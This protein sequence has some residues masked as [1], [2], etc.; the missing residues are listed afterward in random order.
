MSLIPQRKKTPE[1]LAAL[2]AQEFPHG[3]PPPLPPSTVP[4]YAP[5]SEEPFTSA[6]QEAP[7]PQYELSSQRQRH[8]PPEKHGVYHGFEGLK[9][10]AAHLASTGQEGLHA[11]IPAAHAPANKA[12]RKI[13]PEKSGTLHVFEGLRPDS[14]RE[15]QK[16]QVAPQAPLPQRKHDEREIMEMRRRDAFQTRPP[17]QA[18]KNMALHP[19]LAGIFYII[20]AAVV[21]LTVHYWN[22]L[23]PKNFY[24][25]IAGCSLLSLLSLWLYFKKARARHHAA[26]LFGIALVIAGFV[27][28]LTL[29][30]PYA[31]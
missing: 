30:N 26:F 23:P 19:F 31:P 5:P 25:P 15:V 14:A 9:P 12:Y 4:T 7:I 6:P 1:E 28:L 21:Y 2:R 24:A 16:G 11:T 10:D 17:V 13:V 20:A 8:V 18:L 3:P 22:D 27:I 29:K